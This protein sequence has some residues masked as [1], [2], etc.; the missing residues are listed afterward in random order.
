LI[1]IVPPVSTLSGAALE[2][3][4]QPTFGEMLSGLPGVNSS[5]YGPNASRPVIQG[6]DGDRIRILQNGIGTLDA[7]GASVD[8]AVSIDTLTIQACRGRP[9]TGV[10]VT[11]VTA[12]RGGAGHRRSACCKEEGPTERGHTTHAYPLFIGV[13]IG[14]VAIVGALSFFPALLLRPVVE[15]WSWRWHINI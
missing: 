14:T 7:S 12:D 15:H 11:R 2:Q 8:H 4:R 3:A 13:L 6:L 5:Y 1:K 10:Q 9:W